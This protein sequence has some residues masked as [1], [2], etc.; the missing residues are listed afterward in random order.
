LV[1]SGKIII[2]P[3]VVWFVLLLLRLRDLREEDQRE[4]GTK[5]KMTTTIFESIFTN[6]RR[7]HRF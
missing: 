5:E 4:K 6:P 3:G 7:L 2:F 1:S